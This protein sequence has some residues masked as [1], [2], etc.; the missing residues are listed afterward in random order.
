[1]LFFNYPCFVLLMFLSWMLGSQDL[2]NKINNPVKLFKNEAPVYTASR[3]KS[4]IN[5][6]GD[7]NK[8]QWQKTKAVKIKNMMGGKPEFIPST[9]AKVSYDHENVYV[10][11]RV[12]DRHVKCLDREYNGPVYQ[13]SCVEFFFAPDTE[14]PL[15]YFN[16]EI[17]CGGSIL[18]H[19]VTTNGKDHLK[20]EVED[21]KKIEI[22]HSQPEVVD[23][24]IAEPTIWTIEYRIPLSMLEKYS[25]VTYPGPGVTWKANF[26]KIAGKT[27]NPHY[28]T[29]SFIDH[30]TPKFHLPEYFG[31]LKF[32]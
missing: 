17:N 21:L 25:K 23:P 31:T 16:V 6:D 29:W 9:E 8:P 26:F 4:P 13:D 19:Y 14:Q 5:I 1:M 24:E 2:G 18:T 20:L 10:I 27:S 30:P 32:K 11:F 3:L 7:W 15:N 22:A 12:K 28:F